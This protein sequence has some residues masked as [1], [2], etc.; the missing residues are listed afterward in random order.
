MPGKPLGP[1]LLHSAIILVGGL[2]LWRGLVHADAFI[3]SAGAVVVVL[4]GIYAF[5]P[6]SLL[7]YTSNLYWK[8]FITVGSFAI[9]LLGWAYR[10]PLLL[11]AGGYSFISKLTPYYWSEILS[12]TDSRA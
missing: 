2:V 6:D 7:R 8:S 9:L 1:A 5:A 3:V 10:D 12:S 4:H 11:V